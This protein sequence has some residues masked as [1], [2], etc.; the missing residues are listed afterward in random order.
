MAKR[1]RVYA[2]AGPLRAEG[3]VKF[4]VCAS[5]GGERSRGCFSGSL[6]IVETKWC[7]TSAFLTVDNC[8]VIW[9][10]SSIN[11]FNVHTDLYV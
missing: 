4:T 11:S 7:K 10:G 5:M 8:P 3:V 9:N 6:A 2:D 1:F